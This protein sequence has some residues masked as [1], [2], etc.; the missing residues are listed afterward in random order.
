MHIQW[1]IGPT[2]G[3]EVP[4]VTFTPAE[5]L[6]LEGKYVLKAKERFQLNDTEAQAV[7]AGHVWLTGFIL[8]TLA[9]EVLTSI[10]GTPE[11]L[12][13]ELL[14]H[15]TNVH[16]SDGLWARVGISAPDA[17]ATWP[18]ALYLDHVIQFEEGTS[19]VEKVNLSRVKRKLMPIELKKKGTKRQRINLNTYR[20]DRA[21][22]GLNK[23]PAAIL[24]LLGPVHIADEECRSH[25]D[26]TY[27]CRNPEILGKVSDSLTI[28]KSWLHALLYAS[29]KRSGLK[30]DR[31]YIIH[32]QWR[33][34]PTGVEVPYVTFIPTDRLKGEQ[35]L[36]AEE[37]YTLSG[38][39]IKTVKQTQGEE[40]KLQTNL[41]NE[42]RECPI[43][44]SQREA[45]MAETMA[46]NGPD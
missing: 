2:Y 16:L 19:G 37:Y 21:H 34:G 9:E 44:M 7:R 29:Q 22:Y 32:I 45:A 15:N 43:G 24:A 6:R 1:S 28:W 18:E 39:Q 4:Y 8:P 41:P 30:E 14:L 3:V 42:V 36:M 40:A 5:K 23:R 25:L 31:G 10:I 38:D 35:I 27:W 46:Y 20:V 12:R 11:P 13:S 26:D 17:A 33:I